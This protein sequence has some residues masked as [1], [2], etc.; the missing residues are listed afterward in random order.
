MEQVKQKWRDLSLQKSLLCCVL[1][2]VAVD[3]ILCAATASLCNMAV[4]VI[5]EK[6]PPTWEIYY[7]T[8]ERGERLGDGGKIDVNPSPLSK[9]DETK[10]WLLEMFS[11]ISAPVYSAACALLGVALFYRSKLKKPLLLLRAAS[12]KISRSDLDF[13]LRYDGKDEM[14]QLCRSFETMRSILAANFSEMWRQ[15]EERKQLNAAFAHDLRTPL[16]VLKGYNEILQSSPE[17]STRETAATMEKH[18]K[19]L[20]Q[21]VS[22]MSRLHRLE[23]VQPEYR[24]LLRSDLIRS[25]EESGKAE[26]HAHKKAFHFHDRTFSESWQADGCFLSQVCSNLMANAARYAASE[27]T[28]SIKE[29]SGGLC[30]EVSD[31]GKGFSKESLHKAAAPYYT[32]DK[33]SGEHFGLGLYICRTLCER[34]G[35]YLKIENLPKGAK[36]KTFFKVDKK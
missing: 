9:E 14:G 3:F 30:L 18:I 35:G 23:D 34:H 8:N 13:S 5:Q 7:L 12:E 15:I 11:D 31:D 22:S 21:Y 20:E 27:V 32:E 17:P 25:L 10:I 6:Y 19:R 36:V 29:E 28:L 26:C 2:F 24:K 33:D 16:T 4:S 1:L